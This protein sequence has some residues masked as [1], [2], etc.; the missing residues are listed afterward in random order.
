[1]GDVID[2]RFIPI[3]RDFRLPAAHIFATR[4][5]QLRLL[6][7]QGFQ[8]CAQSVAAALQGTQVFVL[9]SGHRNGSSRGRR[10]FPNK[11]DNRRVAFSSWRNGIFFADADAQKMPQRL[12]QCCDQ[13]VAAAAGRETHAADDAFGVRERA[14]RR[15]CG[16][17]AAA[18]LGVTAPI[19][20]KP[21]PS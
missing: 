7:F 5:R 8:Q 15:G 12:F 11:S 9:G 10:L 6:V 17:S 1:M 14:E 3:R 18:S 19:S 21:K 2:L 4:G 16:S 13:C 20:T